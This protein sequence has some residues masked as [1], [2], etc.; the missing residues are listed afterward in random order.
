VLGQEA[1]GFCGPSQWEPMLRDQPD[2]GPRSSEFARRFRDRFGTA[3]DYPAAQ[4]YAAGLIAAEC[5]RRAGS[6]AQDALRRA[7][8]DLDLTTFYGRF[9]LDPQSG[10]QV[11]HAMVVVQWQR[12]RKEIVWPPTAATAPFQSTADTAAQGRPAADTA[13]VRPADNSAQ[14]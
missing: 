1:D 7:A 9:R 13:S 6:L 10:Q 11:G 12:G 14:I 4:A 3:P 5:V 2:L 8:G